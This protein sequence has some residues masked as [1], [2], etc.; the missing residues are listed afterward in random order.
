MQRTAIYPTGPCFSFKV[1]LRWNSYTLQLS[2]YNEMVFSIF[3]Y[4][5]RATITTVNFKTFYHLKKKL[6][7]L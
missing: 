7:I 6:H 5:W 2:I 1:V 3:T 4:M